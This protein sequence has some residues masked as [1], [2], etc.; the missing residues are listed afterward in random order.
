[1]TL[2]IDLQERLGLSDAA[3]LAAKLKSMRGRDVAID[4]RQVTHIGT[5]CQQVL[6]AA[7]KEW[8][9]DGKTLRLIEPTDACVH[10][11]A[12]LGLTPETFEESEL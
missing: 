3:P 6:L 9:A 12:L 7:A 10:H 4:A 2:R 5:L 8:H 1:M 11:L